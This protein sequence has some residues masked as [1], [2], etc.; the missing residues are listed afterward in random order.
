MKMLLRQGKGK[1]IFYMSKKK[2]LKDKWLY[3]VMGV[4]I[5]FVILLILLA[6]K[7]NIQATISIS[8]I[9]FIAPPPPPPAEYVRKAAFYSDFKKK[10][11]ALDQKYLI[12]EMLE[13]P[14]FLEGK[15]LVD[16]LYEIDKSM[17]EKINEYKMQT[18]DFREYV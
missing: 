18:H 3:F 17:I 14:N 6:F 9:Y 5:Y 15:I 1:D 12:V 13:D 8:L 2:Y 7:V 4:C 10:L 16:S 11:E